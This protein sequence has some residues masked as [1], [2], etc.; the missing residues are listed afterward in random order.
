MGMP[1]AMVHARHRHLLICDDKDALF[2][3]ICTDVVEADG[4]G[5][6]K[7]KK[8]RVRKEILL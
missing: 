1:L 7:E 2:R 3:P 6:K 8:P 4:R 5:K